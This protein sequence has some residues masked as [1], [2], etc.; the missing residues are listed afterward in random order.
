LGRKRR[1]KMKK[2]LIFGVLVLCSMVLVVGSVFAIQ[3]YNVKCSDVF[4][5][6][7]GYNQKI[8]DKKPG[9]KCSEYKSGTDYNNENN[10]GKPGDYIQGFIL[11]PMVITKV[12]CENH[13]IISN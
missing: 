9:L 10:Q 8:N 12:V 3:T 5:E 6:D 13:E 7:E 1:K 4:L 2:K 11:A